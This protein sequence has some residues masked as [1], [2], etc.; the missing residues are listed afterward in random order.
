MAHHSRA[1]THV[2]KRAESISGGS[3]TTTEIY[4]PGSDDLLDLESE[5]RSCAVKA[6]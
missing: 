2:L 3:Y 4:G 1:T 5:V 6:T